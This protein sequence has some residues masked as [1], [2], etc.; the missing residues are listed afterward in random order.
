MEAIILAGGVGRR[1][2]PVVSNLPKPM[3]P[4][5]GRPFLE[6]LLTS[7]RTKGIT[8]AIVSVG[9]LSNV[10]TSYFETHPVGIDLVFEIEASPL[11]T[12]GAIAAALRHVT[13]DHVFVFNGDTYLDVDLHALASMW[14]GDRTPIVVARSVPDTERFGR[15]DCAGERI[16][17]FLG[18]G[19]K[20][21]GVINAGCYLIPKDLFAGANT[22]KSFSFEQDF[23]A[24]RP[25]F[26]LRVLPTN[27]QFLD[28]GTPEDYRR[29]QSA[30]AAFA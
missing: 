3:A 17:S 10:I 9:Y 4:V 30:L 15:L 13:S 16:A 25:P 22:P 20:G 19:H 8:R 27:A 11:G 5:A 1:L 29:A 6:L 7:L 28:I 12:G 26:S 14:P 24:Q 2:T 18:S 21:A 23:L